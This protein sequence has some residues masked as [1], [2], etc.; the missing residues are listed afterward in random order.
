[1]I[2]LTEMM[3]KVGEFYY[4]VVVINTLIIKILVGLTKTLAL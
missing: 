3:Y 1:M 2:A 4:S